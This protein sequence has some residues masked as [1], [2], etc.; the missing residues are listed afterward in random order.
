[1]SEILPIDASYLGD[2]F[3]MTF[4]SAVCNRVLDGIQCFESKVY[5]LILFYPSRTLA[6]TRTSSLV[7]LKDRWEDITILIQTKLGGFPK[8]VI[9]VVYLWLERTL[10]SSDITS[11]KGC[12]TGRCPKVPITLHSSCVGGKFN[13][14]PYQSYILSLRDRNTT[15]KR[16]TKFGYNWRRG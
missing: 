15:Y 4:H 16:Q 10:H 7:D 2:I 12:R 8:M 5:W 13:Y 3:L 14:K 9:E 1:M 6:C 11:L